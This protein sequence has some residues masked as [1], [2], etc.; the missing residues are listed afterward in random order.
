MIAAR[1]KAF[2]TRLL[3]HVGGVAVVEFALI[4]PVFTVALLGVLELGHTMYTNAMLTGAIQKAAR[5]STIEGSSVEATRLAIDKRVKTAVQIVA[6]NATVSFK[7]TAFENYADIGRPEDFTDV[8]KDGICNNGETFEDA[9]RN[10]VWD[11]DRGRDGGGGARDAVLYQVTVQYPRLLALP[12]IAGLS[13]K[14]TM[15]TETVLR[16]QPYALNY[17]APKTGTCK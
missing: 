3:N 1:A 2:R 17:A 12:Q 10:G 11:A 6:S 8:N 7:R 9:N 13:P 15:S 14:V 16:N 4:L 5:D